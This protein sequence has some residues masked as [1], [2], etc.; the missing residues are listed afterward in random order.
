[1]KK[2]VLVVLLVLGLSLI[3]MAT[4]AASTAYIDVTAQGSELDIT[5]RK[6]SD[7]ATLWAAGTVDPSDNVFTAINWGEIINN[8]SAAITVTVHGN[9]M[10]DL[11][12]GAGTTWLLSAT[13]AAGAGTIGMWLGVDDAGDTYDTV[14]KDYDNAPYTTILFDAEDSLAS[15]ASWD[16]GL[17]LLAPTS[18][19]GNEA[20]IM[21]DLD[22]GAVGHAVIDAGNGLCFTAAWHP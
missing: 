15:A 17:D 6:I 9:E 19:V 8:S 18:L 11:A 22:G 12:T 16:F 5:V 2:L 14:I 20:M 10:V 7:N 21:T 1:M 13:G 3:P 4:N